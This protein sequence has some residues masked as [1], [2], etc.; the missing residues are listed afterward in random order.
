MFAGGTGGPRGHLGPNAP[1]RPK[2][3]C[4]APKTVDRCE[5]CLQLWMIFL[6]SVA[7]SHWRCQIGYFLVFLRFTFSNFSSESQN[8]HE[9]GFF[10]IQDRFKNNALTLKTHIFLLH[11]KYQLRHI[12]ADLGESPWP[13]ASRIVFSSSSKVN[14]GPSQKNSDLNLWST[15]LFSFGVWWLGY[16]G[17]WRTLTWD[18]SPKCPPHQKKRRL[19]PSVARGTKYK[20]S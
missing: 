5:F 16:G 11:K 13:V 20:Y 6:Q 2:V 8:I 1:Q 7:T 19:D 10:R 17:F 9:I 14:L 15:Y 12:L 3:A 18:P 4:L